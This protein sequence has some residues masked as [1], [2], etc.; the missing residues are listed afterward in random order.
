M[1]LIYEWSVVG[2]VTKT[3]GSNE[4]SIVRVKW[5]KTGYNNEGHEAAFQGSTA[6]SSI[7]TENFTPYDSVTESQVLGWVQSSMDQD[8]E[9]YVNNYINK[10]L[11]R[12]AEPSPTIVES[13]FPW[14]A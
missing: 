7:N 14:E 6:L 2:L 9:D 11:Q 8:E 4:N 3:E 1:S 5:I 12:L 13:G 10:C